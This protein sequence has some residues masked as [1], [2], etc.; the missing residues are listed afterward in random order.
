MESRPVFAPL[1]AAAAG[2]A[3]LAGSIAFMATQVRAHTI[4]GTWNPSGLMV[5]Q[6][7]V[8]AVA[9]DSITIRT[10]DIRPAPEPGRMTP[11]YIIA[12]TNFKA[13]TSHASFDSPTGLPNGPKDI[14]VGDAVVLV[15]P[16]I[17][18]TASTA[19]AWPVTAYIVE[20]LRIPLA[21]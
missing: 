2:V 14:K 6:G 10:P 3:V 15:C 13:D 18:M 1:M 4:T 17:S 12:G 20:K 19:I 9:K 7:H 21:P 8:T 11:M 5:I 16:P